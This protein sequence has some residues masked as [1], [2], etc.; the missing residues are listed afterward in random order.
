MY[1]RQAFSLL[2]PSFAV[3]VLGTIGSLPGAIAAAVII[4]FVRAVSGP[5]L[6]GIGNPIGRSG[7]S[8]LA[9][10]MPYA[11]IIAILLIVP[12]GIGDA[13]D[14]WKIERLR[15]RAMSTKPPDHRLS[16][17]L[18]LLLG[19]LGAHHFHQ[20]RAGRG[21]STLLV[22]SLAFFIGKSTSFIRDHS[23]PV[24]SVVAPDSVDPGIAAQWVSLIE[25]E[26]SVI[27]LMGTI[28]DIL[29]PWVPLL[30][31]AFCLYESYLIA[32]QRYKDPI[33]TLKARYHSL[34]SSISTSRATTREKGDSPMLRDRI[35]SL[36]TNLDYRL[37]TRTTS[38]GVWMGERSTIHMQRVGLTQGR[39]TEAGSKSAFRILMAVL[40]LF[41]VWLPVDPASNFMFA[42][43]LQVSNLVTFLSIYL[44]LSLSLNLS[45]GYTGLLNFGV[46]F[47]ASIGA[48]GVGVLTAPSD[49]AGYGWPIIPALIFSMIVAAISLS[50][51]HI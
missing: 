44:I 38:I 51:I 46:I 5:V 10:V 36:R 48:I 50:L 7:Y 34:L 49:V 3:I 31:W 24:G 42:K 6:I 14:R 40:L 9:E 15:D 2:L 19:P 43:T 20:R 16:A 28:G 30:I 4:G 21:F 22:T 8:A 18:G 27:S 33:Q 39:R 35:E 17:I 25:T 37:T 23:Y 41:V 11:I 45:T 12:K 1:K 47:F 29:W 13:Y 32:N 26:Q